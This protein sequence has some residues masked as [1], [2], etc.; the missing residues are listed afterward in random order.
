MFIH[1]LKDDVYGSRIILITG[2]PEQIKREVLL[3]DPAFDCDMDFRGRCHE[4]INEA[5]GVQRVIV[6]L[7]EWPTG[8]T[9]ISSEVAVL[10][11]E[12]FHATERVMWHHDIDHTEETQ[13][14]WAYFLDS[15]VRRALE[16]L[17]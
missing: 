16:V 15:L 12:L 14:A 13:E 8:K 17:P 2:T 6:M 9:P 11:H 1:T 10:V 7:P 4:H 5:D 3:F